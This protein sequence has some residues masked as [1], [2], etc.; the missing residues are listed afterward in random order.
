MPANSKCAPFFKT[1]RKG[2]GNFYKMK[3]N[4]AKKLYRNSKKQTKKN[5]N[6]KKSVNH[7]AQDHDVKLMS[8]EMQSAL[9][10]YMKL[11]FAKSVRDFGAPS[12]FSSPEEREISIWTTMVSSLL[13]LSKDSDAIDLALLSLYFMGKIPVCYRARVLEDVSFML[14]SISSLELSMNPIFLRNYLQGITY[15]I[16][17]DKNVDK[18]YMGDLQIHVFRETTSGQKE[19]VTDIDEIK[20]ICTIHDLDPDSIYVDGESN[21]FIKKGTKEWKKLTEVVPNTYEMFRPKCSTLFQVSPIHDNN[22]INPSEKVRVNDS[23]MENY[24]EKSY[25]EALYKTMGELKEWGCEWALRQFEKSRLDEAPT[26]SEV[27][28]WFSVAYAFFEAGTKIRDENIRKKMEHYFQVTLARVPRIYRA[29]VLAFVETMAMG[30][31][32]ISETDREEY[33]KGS[34]N[35]LCEKRQKEG[36]DT[37]EEIVY[38]FTIGKEWPEGTVMTAIG[39]V[40]T[41]CKIWSIDFNSLYVNNQYDWEVK[42]GTGEWD[43]CL[44]LPLINQEQPV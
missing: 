10:R 36:S 24:I 9:A 30:H 4:N 26:I 6:S 17:W 14:A 43:K 15:S 12:S 32:R 44:A 3:K 35:V 8:K 27:L 21:C 31:L 28:F 37:V 19:I 11:G 39:D 20:V 38:K 40:R 23:I 5:R 22:S 25:S 41:A 16:S 2:A 33:L 29:R 34:L 7:R 1:P 18:T 42:R 13:I